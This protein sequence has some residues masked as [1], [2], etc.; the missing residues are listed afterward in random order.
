M[1]SFR[2]ISDGKCKAV[3]TKY[4]QIASLRPEGWTPDESTKPAVWLVELTLMRGQTGPSAQSTVFTPLEG[5]FSGVSSQFMRS[6]W[7]PSA[8]LGIPLPFVF[9]SGKASDP[10][11]R[12]RTE[13]QLKERI[14][15]NI[16]SKNII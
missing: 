16:V 14:P 2:T 9:S 13:I 6:P 3:P 15:K 1:R 5:S 8:L 10:F 12:R 11:Y 7:D 4:E